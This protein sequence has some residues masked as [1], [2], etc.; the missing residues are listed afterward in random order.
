MLTPTILEISASIA[1]IINV[2][3]AARANIWNW[4]FGIITVTL[5]AIVFWKVKLFA[6]MS[7]QIVFLLLQ[8][9]G[10]YAWRH[11]DPFSTLTISRCDLLDYLVGTIGLVALFGGYV[12]VLKLTTSTT[13]YIDAI[14]T[15]LSLVAQWLLCRK[16][17]EN[18]L[19]WMIVDLISIKMYV[20]KELYVTSGLYFIFLIICILGYWEWKKLSDNSRLRSYRI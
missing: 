14:T 17:L 15:S 9:Y 4:F 12:F 18:W 11:I 16:R 20:M 6:D 1:A 3:L 7:L 5:Y 19:L 8:F 10:W 2:Y 13:V